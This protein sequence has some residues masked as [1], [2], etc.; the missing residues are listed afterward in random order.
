[1][2]LRTVSA[3]RPYNLIAELTYRCPL[4]CV[5]CS[6]PLGYRAV[7][8]ALDGAA[9]SRV[10]SE[11][12]ALG[13]VHVG[14]TGGEPTLHPDLEEI[15]A[16]AARAS[17]Y[18]HL[19]T[20]GTT[21]GRDGLAALARAGLRSVQLSIQD[22][23]ASASDAIAGTECFDA[24]LAFAEAVR[25]NALALT[26]NV[27]L[28]RHNLARV[29]EITALAQRLGAA[30]LE[31]ANAQYQ[32]WALRNRAALLPTRAQLDVAAQE[33]ARLRRE[34]AGLEILFVLPDYHR[35]RPKPCMGGWGR[36]SIVVAPDG[37]VLPCH[38]AAEL[39][40]LEFWRWPEH[41]LAEC[42]SDAAGMNAFRGE[43]WM[44]APCRDCPER[45]RDFGGCRCQAFALT[46]DASATDPACSL[47]PAHDVI[48][49][50]REAA[51]DPSAP[52]AYRGAATP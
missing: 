51:D 35:D 18:S 24:K 22:A 31:L 47:A 45:M 28:H 15:V 26:L 39:P 16:G 4:R 40:G 20:A 12:A 19:V 5:Y 8:D 11:A 1:V 23:E 37:C 30:R 2:Y 33:V 3:P 44:P 52:F 25:E 6:N 7:R 17:L 13:T 38:G 50:A 43:A 34:T 49:R 27:V 48:L 10:F 42:W 29:A 14:L 21:Q 46:G 32:G 36:Q 9:W 41:S